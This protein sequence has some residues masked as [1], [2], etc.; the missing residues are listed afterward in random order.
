MDMSQNL[1]EENLIRGYFLGDLAEGEQE[2]VEERLFT[3]RE[4]FETSLVIEG[5]LVDDYALGLLPKNEREKLL[6]R[7]LRTPQ[8]YQKVR[9]AKILEQYISNTQVSPAP[10]EGGATPQASLITRLFS[11]LIPWKLSEARQRRRS[12]I[13]QNE[14]DAWKRLLGEAQ[15]NR[16]LVFSLIA[17]DWLGLQLLLRLREDSAMTLEGLTDGVE[18][19]DA[20]LI[21]ALT[22]LIKCGL[23]VET[24]EV[25]SCSML[26]AEMLEKIDKLSGS[27]LHA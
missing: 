6:R 17:D 11:R 23:V 4:F 21:T 13:G 12:D 25:F 7:F 27:D 8:Q 24:Q 14:P 19:S 16:N 22:R 10:G 5:E 18:G 3:D 1:P 26:G 9:L 2:R 15:S 20:D